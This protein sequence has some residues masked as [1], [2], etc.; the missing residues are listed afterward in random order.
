MATASEA[1]RPGFPLSGALAVRHWAVWQLPARTLYPVLLV[2]LTTV[3]LACLLLSRQP[4][5]MFAE[6]GTAALLAFAGIAH[7]EIALGVE[8]VRRRIG[9]GNIVDLSS[10]WTFAAALV[11]PAFDAGLVAVFIYGYFWCRAWRL[12]TPLY[13]QLFSMSTVALACFASSSVLHFMIDGESLSQVGT[14]VVVAGVI[15][16]LLVYTAVNTCLVAGAIALSSTDPSLTTLFAS[17]DENLLEV[18]TLCLGA[19]TAAA[20]L[21]NPWLVLLVLPPL[22]V[23]HRAALVRQLQEA[24]STDS[25]TGLLNAAAW[26]NRVEEV[27]RRSGAAKGP[28]PTG[29]LVID[30]DHFKAINDTHGHIAGDCVLS[31]VA[32]AL[33]D[34]VR[35]GD[36][37]GRFG[38]EEFVVLL[39]GDGPGDAD[40]VVE[41]AQRLRRRIETLC[42]EIS[43]PDGPLSLASVSASVGV[44]VV[45]H[46]SPQL[47][48]LMHAADAALFAAKRSGRN[49]VQLAA[50]IPEP[51]ES[52]EPDPATPGRDYRAL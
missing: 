12:R 41:A 40:D 47:S 4:P 13:R 44:V 1:S 6:V 33:E 21:I 27:F 34:E 52:T 7:A 32:S 35:G 48:L 11:L 10:I 20:L 43:T 14:P 38:G 17:W 15:L 16:A 2:E 31:A 5:P 23:L 45:D 49:R 18:A 36:L 46:T 8:R 22:I 28:H 42:V 37:V 50:H 19:L 39:T 30:L 51:A 24:A 25:K 29:V 26:H 9:Q 3:L